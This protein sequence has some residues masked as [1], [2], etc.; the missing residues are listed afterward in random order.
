MCARRPPPGSGAKGACKITMVEILYCTEITN[1]IQF[2][3]DVEDQ[4]F[5]F[6]KIERSK[7][8][9]RKA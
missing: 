9:F 3:A 6:S 1:Y 7:S 4:F 2:R 5:D 8:N